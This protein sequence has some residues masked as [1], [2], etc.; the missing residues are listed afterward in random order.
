MKELEKNYNPNIEDRI[1][2]TWLD[3]KYFKASTDKNKK[4][5]TIMMPPPNITGRLHLGH[6]L[7]NTIQDVLVR[8]KRMDGYNTLWLPGTDHAS[9]STEVKVIEKLLKEGIR[10]K[11]IGREKFVEE[12]WVWKKKYGEEIIEQIKKTG[13]SCDFDK[14]RFTLDKGLNEAVNFTFVNLYNEGLLYKGE[15][16]INWCPKCRTTISDAEV[17]H[18]DIDGAFWHFKYK[19][20]GTDEYLEFATTRPETILGDTGI[21]VNPS[22][23]R[24]KKYIG[25]TVIVPIVNREIP[26][27]GDRY[28][29]ADFGTGVVKITPAHDPND[30]EVGLR[31]NLPIINI[32]NDDGSMN[33]TT[34]EY[35]G[36]DRYEARKKIVEDFDKLGL[37]VKKKPITHAVGKH[38]RCKV[39]VEPLMKEQWFVKMEELS[40]QALEVYETGELK[41]IPNRLGK[42]YTN[43]LENSRDW[44]ISRQLWWGHRIPAY[45]CECGHIEVK[46]TK[47]LKCSKCDSTK[48][49]QDEDC[50]DTWFSSAL[51]PFSTLGWPNETEDMKNFYP[52]DLIVTGYDIIFFWIVRMVFS[53]LHHTK[54]LPFKEVYF[55]GLIKDS[56][57]R[58]M[59]KSLGNG[60]DPIEV[61]EKYGSD[62]LRLTLLLGNS[63]GNDMKFNIKDVENNR[64]FLNKIWNATRFV[65]MNVNENNIGEIKVD[66]N[67]IQIEDKW[68][69]SKVNNLVEEVRKNID[70]Y[71][72]SIAVQKVYSFIWDEYCDWYIE[73]VKPRLYDED[74]KTRDSAL[75]TLL[76]V[77]K[78]SL[79]LLHPFM[80]FIT[81]EIFT[82]I[83]PKE[84]TIMLSSWPKAQEK[85]NFEKDEKEIEYIKEV[86]K[87]IR[88]TRSNMNV[89]PSK[90]VAIYVV[91]EKED[92][93][94]TFEKCEKF[95][96][97][98]G[99]A[100][101]L[102]VQNNNDGIKDDFVSIVIS[103]AII[104]IPFTDL[105]DVEKE[106]ER[107]EKEKE[108]LIKEVYR[109]INKLSNK[110]FTDKAPEKLINIE[111]EK[112]EKYESMLKEVKK[113]IEKIKK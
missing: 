17:D 88:L 71:E 49:T 61:I 36:L 26:I 5:F 7:N 22:D 21:A 84:K 47:P 68:I 104:Y 106:I 77:L 93:K 51:W 58:K 20:K 33:S 60:I 111:K 48:L 44:C 42:V 95:M 59:S 79:K 25:K 27:V 23:E 41:L 99:Y 83:E 4:T 74:D 64:T 28:A 39:V 65:L 16:L 10:K 96:K 72:L 82:T 15:K 57:G 50:L 112:Q 110:G 80:P 102:I 2:K 62:A 37:F 63:P 11:D 90:K 12:V 31:H 18:E 3:N 75:W 85:Y 81:E 107:L 86:I 38:E 46:E 45:Y 56:K 35:E 43:W 109:V 73:M 55:T 94:M 103:D 14:Q 87:N 108:K 98:L 113:Q 34:G 101:K 30:F 66:K 32:M 40:K 67:N 76:E 53:G 52:T 89:K 29:K 1:Y 70:K 19:V 24:Y 6:A 91:T 78:I 100:N 92:V 9:I 105:V 13:S 8:I 97:T 69:L 54:K